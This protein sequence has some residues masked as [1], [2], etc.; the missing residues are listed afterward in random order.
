MEGSCRMSVRELC[1][2]DD[3]ATSLVLDPLLGFSTHKMN[4]SQPPEIRRWGYLREALLRFKHTQDFQTTFEALLVGD[5]ACGYFTNLGIHRLEMLRQH[6]YRYLT[7]FLLD[8]G[9]HIESCDRYSSET[10]GAKITS[11]RHWAVGERMEVLQGC[12]AE[13][14]PAD[15]AVLRAGVNDF[16]VMYSTRK[17]CAQLWLGPAAFINHDCR[18]NCK[19]VPGEKNGACVKVI[20]PISPGEEITC[21]YGDSFFGEDN[22]MCE[23]CTCERRGQGSF[24]Q[25]ET[26]KDY[27]DNT[28]PAGRKYKFRETDLR[29][30]AMKGN[31]TST[32]IFPMP[33]QAL[34]SRNSFS[35][36]MKRNAQ[37]LSRSLTKTSRWRREQCAS[38]DRRL[39]SDD[40]DIHLSPLCD[41]QLKDVSVCLY[42]HTTDFL[43]S[44]KDPVGGGRELLCRIE[45]ARP[46]LDRGVSS[47]KAFAPVTSEI[48]MSSE[49][50][51]SKCSTSST[52][53][54]RKNHHDLYKEPYSL[55]PN[56]F[57]RRNG[58]KSS[59]AISLRT[60]SMLHKRQRN[61][62]T[63]ILNR[64]KRFLKSKRARSKN[65]RTVK[66]IPDCISATLRDTDKISEQINPGTGLE[67]EE[68]QHSDMSHKDKHLI[69]GPVDVGTSGDGP[70]DL[71]Q[72]T[73]SKP[74]SHRS[75]SGLTDARPATSPSLAL[76]PLSFR[77]LSLKAG[78]KLY[79]TVSLMRVQVP[80]EAESGRASRIET[81]KGERS[82]CRLRKRRG[83]GRDSVAPDGKKA[84]R[85]LYFTPV[86]THG[87]DGALKV[88]CN[89]SHTAENDCNATESVD[90]RPQ[91]EVATE[92]RDDCTFIVDTPVEAAKSTW[93]NKDKAAN[94]ANAVDEMSEA[95]EK[96]EVVAKRTGQSK[97]RRKSKKGRHKVK[98][99]VR[100]TGEEI[101]GEKSADNQNE[102]AQT[103]DCKEKKADPFLYRGNGCGLIK[104]VKVLLTDVFCKTR[105][106]LKNSIHTDKSLH[107]L[108][109]RPRK[110]ENV[111]D[112][113][114]RNFLSRLA[115]SDADRLVNSFRVVSCKDVEVQ[116]KTKIVEQSVPNQSTRDTS[117]EQINKMPENQCKISGSRP[118]P[119]ETLPTSS[120]LTKEHCLQTSIPLK[121]RTFRESTETD[122][123]MN[124]NLTS[125]DSREATLTENSTGQVMQTSAT[126][127]SASK[128][129]HPK[130]ANKKKNAQPQKSHSRERKECFR[131]TRKAKAFNRKGH[132]KTRPVVSTQEEV[133]SNKKE[134]ASESPQS[135][136]V[137]EGDEQN[138]KNA[139][140]TT[141]S[142][143]QSQGSLVCTEE[144]EQEVENITGPKQEMLTC[145]LNESP[146]QTSCGETEEKQSKKLKIRLK[147]KRGEEW[148]MDEPEQG[149]GGPK[150]VKSPL[151]ECL[152]ADPFKAILDSVSVLNLEMAKGEWGPEEAEKCL[153]L[154][155]TAKAGQVAWEICTKKIQPKPWKLKETSC[156]GSNL[157]SNANLVGDV[158]ISSGCKAQ[159]GKNLRK[160]S[161]PEESEHELLK[162][163]AALKV[164]MD[165]ADL[166]VLS[167]IRLRRKAAGQWIVDEKDKHLGKGALENSPIFSD[168]MHSGVLTFHKVKEER[169]SP[170]QRHKQSSCKVNRNRPSLKLEQLPLSLSP[171]SLN[172]PYPEE[173]AEQHFNNQNIRT[174]TSSK[175]MSDVLGRNEQAKK[176][177]GNDFDVKKSV[178]LSQNLLQ[179]NKSLSRLQALTQPEKIASDNGATFT[180]SQ[181]K[182]QSPLMLFPQKSP[183][184]NSDFDFVN[185][186]EDIM[187]FPCLN[188]EGYYQGNTQT[189][190]V[191]FCPAEPQH[192]G[193]FSSPFSQSP[194]NAWNPETP[195]L[196]SPSP[197]SRFSATEDLGFP[198]FTLS[199]GPDLSSK[200]RMLSNQDLCFGSLKDSSGGRFSLDVPLA[201][202]L[203]AKEASKSVQLTE[204]DKA[205]CNRRDLLLFNRHPPSPPRFQTQANRSIGPGCSLNLRAASSR[206]EFA[207]VPPLHKNHGA[208]YPQTSSN[209]VQS[210]TTSRSVAGSGNFSVQSQPLKPFHSPLFGSKSTSY[211]QAV[212]G[213]GDMFP[214]IYDKKPLLNFVSNAVKVEG[215]RHELNTCRG[216]VTTESQTSISSGQLSFSHLNSASGFRQGGLYS[217]NFGKDPKSSLHYTR[218]HPFYYTSA[219]KNHPGVFP[220]LSTDKTQTLGSACIKNISSQKPVFSYNQSSQSHSLPLNKSTN[221]EKPH[222]MVAPTQNPHLSCSE[223][224]L[225][226]SKQPCFSHCDPLDFSFS[227]SLSPGVSQP[228]SP[229]V[230]HTNASGQETQINKPQTSSLVYGHQAHPPYVVNFTGDHSVTM[231]Y[232][233]EAEAL[234]YSGVTTPNYTYHCLMEPSG[235]QGR[236]VLEPCGPSSHS[237]LSSP[238]LGGFSGLKGQEERTRKD[239]QLPGQP[240]GHQFV[241]HHF[242]TSGHSFGTS[243][244]ER[245]PKRLRLVVTD[246][247]VDLDL[248]YTD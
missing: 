214:R 75:K 145:I 122:S 16:S 196:G 44:C 127:S 215:G 243:L 144:V 176:D 95:G 247:T 229:H 228:D 1:E 193:S 63:R 110:H 126:S 217:Q 173:V 96:I 37:P 188:L 72:V 5:W 195:Y 172:S 48:N 120:L 161:I 28:D 223:S 93:L 2:T 202:N 62:N 129:E 82:A 86:N 3:L 198:D 232:S 159:L 178:C 112:K 13:L 148:E 165:D 69:L 134:L 210:C 42:R 26:Q 211:P 205:S 242:S 124:M 209:K 235:T 140:C 160:Q 52:S 180:T 194:P 212:M 138:V 200:E 125:P 187:D 25:R 68:I 175:K 14:S 102:D 83:C 98:G 64:R 162:T 106:E 46:K 130:V 146:F 77:H 183:L 151:P 19:F 109:A 36:R 47:N 179:I 167:P 236:L 233:E 22:E 181:S 43:L 225:S 156:L 216:D 7:A 142:S 197:G 4:I 199:G 191:D 234:N 23:C 203:S 92:S 241:S 71:E 186:E 149:A 6:V 132:A 244:S 81:D 53:W 87:A 73:L 33:N 12:I 74:S 54:R 227:S 248:H 133:N 57:A 224:S 123:D 171:L 155:Q 8:S 226:T 101:D 220:N 85:E 31:G 89:M 201:K 237:Y 34:S 169:E 66:R 131:V 99:H 207:K 170:S 213:S 221:H 208:T 11:T 50:E 222:A 60:R 10:N 107:S 97:F 105:E 174:R 51:D 184:T 206:P 20:R 80:G 30:R 79:P 114:V 84:V 118:A 88:M 192:T 90:D 56:S 17:R 113:I 240:G 163:E 94:N 100:G 9:V 246:G 15:S 147:R 76:L 185:D 24:R 115:S 245:K 111:S 108:V 177:P 218:P 168:V 157:V 154:A 29:L 204:D 58:R 219:S 121:K 65:R 139:E 119:S 143:D 128:C 38:V 231:G 164:E 116:K 104:E 40:Q 39:S 59:L 117:S 182:S 230:G 78:L 61:L 27:E 21:Y 150:K 49:E 35:Q 153:E 189:S 166:R 41:F 67:A 45:S 239:S 55:P 137:V 32:T 18:P 158:N 135:Q 141:S 190:L 136:K 70:A 103:V 152:L 238:S 91:N